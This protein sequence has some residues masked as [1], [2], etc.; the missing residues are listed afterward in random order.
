MCHYCKTQVLKWIFCN[1]FPA[2]IWIVEGKIEGQFKMCRKTKQ[3]IKK[4]LY[5]YA[6]KQ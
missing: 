6:K 1:I 2:S 3:K 4:E 5:L